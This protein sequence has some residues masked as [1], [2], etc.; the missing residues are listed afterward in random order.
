MRLMQEYARL[1]SREMRTEQTLSVEKKTCVVL[2]ARIETLERRLRE[3]QEHGNH[4]VQKRKEEGRESRNG[5]RER[6][7]KKINRMVI[8][9]GKTKNKNRLCACSIVCCAS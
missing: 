8:I 3:L 9:Q 2:Q 6:P 1:Q 5:E 4:Q 7:G